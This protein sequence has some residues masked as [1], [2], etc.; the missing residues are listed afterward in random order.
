MVNSIYLN[1]DAFHST[2]S[3]TAPT[4]K[5]C[6][7]DNQHWNLEDPALLLNDIP[8]HRDFER[9]QIGKH[10]ESDGN[11]TAWMRI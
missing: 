8:I 2:E 10:K 1:F 11:R 3:A 6:E 5:W 7:G 4:S 9:I